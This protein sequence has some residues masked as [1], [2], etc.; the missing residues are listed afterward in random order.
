MIDFFFRLAYWKENRIFTHL[1]IPE[2]RILLS[3]VRSLYPLL[4]AVTVEIGSYLGAS[5]VFLAKGLR[6]GG[7]LYCVDTWKNQ[8]MSEGA[9]DTYEAF[10]SN[11]KDYADRI[12]PLRGFSCDVAKSFDKKIDLM[13]FDGDHSEDGVKGDVSSWFPKLKPGAVVVFHDYGWAEGVQKT[14]REDVLP[15]TSSHKSLPN[16][17]WGILK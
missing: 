1:T 8:G 3:L 12:V 10:L 11:T 4:S 5:S 14:I 9:R 15:L 13:F 7:K 6:S 2:K 17:W 16:M